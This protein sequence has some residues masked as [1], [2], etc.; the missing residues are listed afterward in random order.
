MKK[1][2]KLCLDGM[3]ALFLFL[4]STLS[5]GQAI[6]TH[7]FGE[8]AWMPDTIGTVVYNGKLHTQWNNIQ[9]SGTKIIRFGGVAP[10]RDMPTNFQYIRMID[11]VRAHGIEPI[12]SVPFNNYQYTA[13]QAAAI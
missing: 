9:N 3:I 4:S 7:F 13:A 10:D 2:S 8:N 5:F 11:S 6:S 1:I 12:I